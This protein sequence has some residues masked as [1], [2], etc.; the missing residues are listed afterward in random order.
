MA[1]IEGLEGSGKPLLHT[2]GSSVISDNAREAAIVS[3]RRLRRFH[4]NA[5]PLQMNLASLGRVSRGGGAELD[6]HAG[7]G[8]KGVRT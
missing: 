8:P 6:M 7:C 4:E 5:I 3:A 1:L 2:S